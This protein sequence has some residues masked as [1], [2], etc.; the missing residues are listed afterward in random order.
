[1]S[2]RKRAEEALRENAAL[3]SSLIAQAP[4]GTYVVDAQFRMRQVNAEA[5]PTFASVRPLIGRDFQE[6]IEIL[7]GPD[8][9]GQMRTSPHAWR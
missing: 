4:M 1:M 5:M 9:G 6:A 7:W 2:E 3:F 8:V